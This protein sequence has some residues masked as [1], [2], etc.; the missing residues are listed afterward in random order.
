MNLLH[1]KI[2]PLNWKMKSP[3]KKWLLEKNPIL[4]TAIDIYTSLIK[5]HKKIKLLENIVWL[6]LRL[7]NKLTVIN[8]LTKYIPFLEALP[9]FPPCFHSIPTPL[10]SPS[11]TPNFEEPLP[12]LF[13]TCGKRSCPLNSHQDVSKGNPGASVV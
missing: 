1:W 12:H 2:L 7:T 11:A 5:Q 8:V 13:Y 9:I 6:D 3:S 10:P 4:G